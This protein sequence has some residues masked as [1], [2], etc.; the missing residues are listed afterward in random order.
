MTDLYAQLVRRPLSDKEGLR[1]GRIMTLIWGL[2]FII[3]ANLFRGTDSPVVELGLSVA[4]ITYGGLLGA[5]FL[6]LFV[7]RARQ[8]DAVVGFGIAVVVMAYLFVF[9]RALIG[10]TWFT[11]IGVAITMA[12]GGGLSLRHGGAPDDSTQPS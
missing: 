11:A 2:V 12:V 8:T 10:F 3:F 1:L 9:E 5:F 6:G 7:R 4:G